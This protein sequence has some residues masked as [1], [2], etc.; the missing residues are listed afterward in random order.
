MTIRLS[1]ALVQSS[2][3]YQLR[4]SEQTNIQAVL[5]F[6]STQE[7]RLDATTLELV[8][9]VASNQR[10]Q[11]INLQ[12]GDRL[13]IFIQAAHPVEIPPPLKL[14]D[15]LL[16]FSA[17]QFAAHSSGKKSL[18]VGKAD[19]TLQGLPDIDLQQFIPT[20]HLPM[21]SPQCLWLNFDERARVWYV[22]RIGH[23]RILLDELE[24]STAQVALNSTHSLRFYPPDNSAAPLYGPPLA[25]LQ[26]QVEL[27]QVAQ[28]IQQIPPGDF[29]LNLR[30]G[31]EH[32]T[33]LIRASENITFDQIARSLA[34]YNSLTLTPA[35]SLCI[36]R[37]VSP[38][39]TMQA[40]GL[41]TEA[42][43]YAPL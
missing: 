2:R 38:Q 24:L 26:V 5:N 21:I 10:I 19:P 1:T 28:H 6:L 31:M 42:F 34:Q 3:H 4:T 29:L 11:E 32:E 15:R 36:A 43:L 39:A 35:S 8:R 17:P 18:I 25:E 16:H 37:L 14:G 40:L 7:A 41:G 30:V 33:Q 20:Q 13:L 12:A 22:S 23:T 27:V 9:P